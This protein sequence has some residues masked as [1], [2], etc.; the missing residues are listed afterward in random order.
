LRGAATRR[1]VSPGEVIGPELAVPLGLLVTEAIT[2]A[3]KHAF[4]ERTQGTIRVELERESSETLIIRIRDNGSGF[5]PSHVSQDTVGLG[6]S[7]IE[8][9]VRQLHGELQ[10]TSQDGTVVEVRFPA[11]ERVV[12]RAAKLSA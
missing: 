5:D 2:N 1:I 8:A 3:Y 4:G 12:Q 9:F 6:R 7:L 10:I 11:K